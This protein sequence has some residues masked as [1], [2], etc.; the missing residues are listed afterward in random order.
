M[1]EAVGRIRELRELLPE[2]MPIQV[3]G[4]IGPETIRQAYDAGA[5]LFVAG[6][7]IFGREDVVRAYRRLVAALA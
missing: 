2:Q 3:D 5:N 1:P 6:S 4:G 7:S